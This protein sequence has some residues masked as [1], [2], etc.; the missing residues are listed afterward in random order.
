MS[1]PTEDTVKVSGPM[2]FSL[3]AAGARAAAALFAVGI[4][5]LLVWMIDR[6]D[7]KAIEKAEQ[8]HREVMGALSEMVYVLTLPQDRR[9]ALNLSMPDS[10]RGKVRRD[11]GNREP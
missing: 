9:E 2:G 11:R 6:H 4:T 3:E 1:P 7:T 8:N 5:A 10:L